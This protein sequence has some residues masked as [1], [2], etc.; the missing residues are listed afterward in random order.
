MPGS[1]ISTIR[2]FAVHLAG[3][4][5]TVLILSFSLVAALTVA[6]GTWATFRVIEDYL[7]LAEEAR[8]GRDMHWPRPSTSS[9]SMKWPP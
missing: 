8:V 9:N 1:P 7:S 4:L 6:S 5:Q 2:E 3:S